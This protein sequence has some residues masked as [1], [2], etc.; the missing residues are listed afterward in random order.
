MNY[1]HRNNEGLHLYGRKN[2]KDYF[3]YMACNCAVE[4]T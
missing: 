2:Y 4:G 3:P 1:G